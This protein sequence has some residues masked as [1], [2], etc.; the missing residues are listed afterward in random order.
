[1][2]NNHCHLVTTH[3]QS[4]IIIIIIII[5]MWKCVVNFT[6]WTLYPQGKYRSIPTKWV[7]EWTTEPFRTPVEKKIF[8]PR[9]DRTQNASIRTIVFT[10]NIVGWCVNE[11]WLR[12]VSRMILEWGNLSTLHKAF[13]SARFS[14]IN[15]ILIRLGS[16]QTLHVEQPRTYVLKFGTCRGSSS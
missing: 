7:A 14:S 2:H 1:M 8:C 16:S 4:I 3:L 15:P 9:W 10:L 13:K 5:I 6:T 12:S 11:K